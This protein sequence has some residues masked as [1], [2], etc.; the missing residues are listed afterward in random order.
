MLPEFQESKSKGLFFRSQSP[1]RGSSSAFARR[2]SVPQGGD[3]GGL[4][5]PV[6]KIS[7]DSFVTLNQPFSPNG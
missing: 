3:P 5:A 6:T 2:P 7:T 4:K 1:G